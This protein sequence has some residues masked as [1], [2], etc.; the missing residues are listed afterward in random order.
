MSHNVHFLFNHTLE[1]F[2][3]NS[4]LS[5]PYYL[6]VMTYEAEFDDVYDYFA[7]NLTPAFIVSFV[8]LLI[9]ACLSEFTGNFQLNQSELHSHENFTLLKGDSFKYQRYRFDF[10]ICVLFQ[11]LYIGPDI[12]GRN[13]PMLVSINFL[14]LYFASTG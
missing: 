7:T 8:L 4:V 9:L 10:H 6:I 3:M 14:F 5:L 1:V 2:L 11:G 12:R 13:I